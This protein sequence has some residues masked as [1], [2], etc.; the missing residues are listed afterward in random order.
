M[1]IKYDALLRGIKAAEQ[2]N[3]IIVDRGSNKVQE[4]S[5]KRFLLFSNVLEAANIK[6]NH[7]NADILTKADPKYKAKKAD[8]KTRIEG[9]KKL[10][11][12]RKVNDIYA[13]WKK[14]GSSEEI[15]K[16]IKDLKREQKKLGEVIEKLTEF[17]NTLGKDKIDLNLFEE[18]TEIDVKE[19]QELNA[20]IN[21][22]KLR[23]DLLSSH[24]DIKEK[25][26]LSPE[27]AIRIL[28]LQDKADDVLK[29]EAINTL[30]V[31]LYSDLGLLKDMREE[32]IREAES[33]FKS[34]NSDGIDT[35]INKIKKYK[36][37]HQSVSEQMD[38]IPHRAMSKEAIKNALKALN[39]KALFNVNQLIAV[40]NDIVNFNNDASRLSPLN[41]KHNVEALDLHKILVFLKKLEDRLL[42]EEIKVREEE[43][44]KAHE[45]IER[46]EPKISLPFPNLEGIIESQHAAI[47]EEHKRKTLIF[48]SKR[49]EVVTAEKQKADDKIKLKF[50]YTY[51]KSEILDL[52]GFPYVRAYEFYKKGMP[53][54]AGK[55]IW[56]NLLD[57]TDKKL[58]SKAVFDD[59]AKEIFGETLDP[60][61]YG[62][63]VKEIQLKDIQSL[64]SVNIDTLSKLEKT[65]RSDNIEALDIYKSLLFLKE[66]EIRLF[67][68]DSLEGSHLIKLVSFPF[69]S[70]FEFYQKG[71][72]LKAGE[73]IFRYF[74]LVSD[75]IP[76][77]ADFDEVA[78]EIFGEGLDPII[79]GAL[80][81]EF[82]ETKAAAQ[83]DLVW[84][85]FVSEKGAIPTWEQFK[86][87]FEERVGILPLKENYDRLIQNMN[88]SNAR[89]AENVW[90]HLYGQN[91]SPPTWND[92][93]IFFKESIG[94]EPEKTLY[95]DLVKNEIQAKENRLIDILNDLKLLAQYV[96]PRETWYSKRDIYVQNKLDDLKTEI[97]TINRTLI[98][99]ADIL[100]NNEKEKI[101]K[102]LEDA[103]LARES[104]T[105]F[106]KNPTRVL[107]L[108]EAERINYQLEQLRKRLLEAEK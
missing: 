39:D 20:S 33:L 7:V 13:K 41:I 15:A 19:F 96:R 69:V 37:I 48:D 62:A 75:K 35:Y 87:A 76:S 101:K 9:E 94:I 23:Q 58:P 14:S 42:A 21:A 47:I 105:N 89:S 3:H 28:K 1:G 61:I 97:E 4:V 98:D 83:G 34:K 99:S 25:K 27:R 107:L 24:I 88:A 60:K 79:Y 84:F 92:F 81:K 67:Q 32:L 93:E 38:C 95:L 11:Q 100:G 50:N 59:V 103:V 16:E 108:E 68:S 70:A 31:R 80:V 8:A 72:L 102:Q 86:Q 51:V 10:A 12:L 106:L 71:E 43:R 74:E 53:L 63:L 104:I 90:I 2:D 5:L 6:L 18:V 40:R 82:H 91:K 55:E 26:A 54:E 17:K 46:D 30:K 73:E 85:E 64:I 36:A 56:K 77:Q 66:L 29:N 49:D 45:A 22:L 65:K 52:D 44:S 57:R 78:R